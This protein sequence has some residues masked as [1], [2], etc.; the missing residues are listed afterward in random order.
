MRGVLLQLL[1]VLLLARG[2]PGSAGVLDRHTHTRERSQHT[3]PHPHGAPAA[4]A[5]WLQ[6][7]RRA[8]GAACYQFPSP[9]TPPLRVHPVFILSQRRRPATMSASSAGAARPTA[10]QTPLPRCAHPVPP[11]KHV[12]GFSG[13]AACMYINK[14][15]KSAGSRACGLRQ[16]WHSCG[17]HPARP[18]SRGPRA[19]SRRSAGGRAPSSS[20]TS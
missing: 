20:E 8:H 1:V 14:T 6:P 5:C 13:A 19:G 3:A 17:P 15:A 7:M 9:P 12:L 10:Q 2:P 18:R 16:P 4:A 11:S